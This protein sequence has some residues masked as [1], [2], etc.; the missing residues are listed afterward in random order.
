MTAWIPSKNGAYDHRSVYDRVGA[1][2]TKDAEG[3][4]SIRPCLTSSP[5]FVAFRR[6]G[7]YLVCGQKSKLKIPDE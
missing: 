7:G 3:R 6:E 4:S 2:G 1:A 5:E